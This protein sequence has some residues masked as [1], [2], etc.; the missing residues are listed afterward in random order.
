MIVNET[1]LNV[2]CWNPQVPTANSS[3][4]EDANRLLH[5]HS[6]LSSISDPD[7]FELCSNSFDVTESDG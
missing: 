5:S 2:P 1:T 4:T 3:A 7:D 6:L